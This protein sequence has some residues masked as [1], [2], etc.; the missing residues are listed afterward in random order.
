[1]KKLDKG[2]PVFQGL[3]PRPQ[4]GDGKP[5]ISGC[6]RVAIPSFLRACNPCVGFAEGI[7]M[8]KST[9]DGRPWE[10]WDKT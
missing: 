1:L 6:F 8:R 9:P 4:E 5:G 3:N 7:L 10:A 2:F